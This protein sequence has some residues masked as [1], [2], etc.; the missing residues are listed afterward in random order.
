MPPARSISDDEKTLG[1]VAK[2]LADLC[3]MAE[4]GF[5]L[6]LAHEICPG[7]KPNV[8]SPVQFGNGRKKS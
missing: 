1:A 8:G 5:K 4:T 3:R 6:A 2:V 7:F